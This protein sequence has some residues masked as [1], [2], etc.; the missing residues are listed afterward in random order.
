MKQFYLINITFKDN[1][2]TIHGLFKYFFHIRTPPLNAYYGVV[3][4]ISEVIRHKATSV[5][6][7]DGGIFEFVPGISRA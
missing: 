1:Q 6:H 4:E 5:T 2:E 3:S 7:L